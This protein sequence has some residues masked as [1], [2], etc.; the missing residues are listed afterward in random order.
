MQ[1]YRIGQLLFSSWIINKW[2]YRAAS[3]TSK[4]SSNR[5][6]SAFGIFSSETQSAKSAVSCLDLLPAVR[7]SRFHC[8][9]ER[10]E[11]PQRS[12]RIVSCSF[13]CSPQNARLDWTQ[14]GNSKLWNFILPRKFT[15]QA[16]RPTRCWRCSTFC[17]LLR[18]VATPPVLQT[19][20]LLVRVSCGVILE[21]MNQLFDFRKH[22]AVIFLFS[23][24]LKVFCNHW[25]Y[26]RDRKFSKLFF[27]EQIRLNHW[28]KS[29]F[30]SHVSLS[31]NLVPCSVGIYTIVAWF[32]HNNYH[33][34]NYFIFVEKATY[35]SRTKSEM[36][37]H[38]TAKGR[39]NG[40]MER[41]RSTIWLK[42]KHDQVMKKRR[43]YNYSIFSGEVVNIRNVSVWLCFEFEKP[44]REQ[45]GNA[46]NVGGQE[47]SFRATDFRKLHSYK[48]TQRRTVL[49]CGKCLG[50]IETYS[51]QGTAVENSKSVFVIP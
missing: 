13:R 17:S 20:V 32:S 11:R 33:F 22:C 46:R 10:R 9:L 7:V 12:V 14:S 43:N 42:K 15:L 45:A 24:L 41:C 36:Y 2:S 49:L 47:N 48:K 27:F 50:T 26:K 3:M 40:I 51:N 16:H 44:L 38:Q 34:Y 30:F 25:L 5:S 39:N 6:D 19:G 29:R 21:L 37:K 28:T 1:Y 23:I 8:G 35:G 4:T 31:R 18:F